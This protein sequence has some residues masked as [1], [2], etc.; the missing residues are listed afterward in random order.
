M[1]VVL[2]TVTRHPMFTISS[3]AM[4]PKKSMDG[5]D[6]GA[7]D[8]SSFR[9]VRES[10]EAFAKGTFSSSCSWELTLAYLNMTSRDVLEV[11][12]N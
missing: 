1:D 7:G 11:Q 4:I 10:S 8:G 5:R 9:V 6:E 2:E 3:T 12:M